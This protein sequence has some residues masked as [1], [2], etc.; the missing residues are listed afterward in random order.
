MAGRTQLI[1]GISTEATEGSVTFYSRAG[2]LI[3]TMERDSPAQH[4][5]SLWLY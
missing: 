1:G 3:A 2:L 4:W 5:Y